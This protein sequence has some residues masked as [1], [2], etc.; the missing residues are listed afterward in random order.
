MS[1]LLPADIIA[2]TTTAS[3]TELREDAGRYS[4]DLEVDAHRLSDEALSDLASAAN[5]AKQP[6]IAR[7]LESIRAA[8]TGA[9]SRPIPNF[10]AFKSVLETFLRRD[11]I[12]GWIYVQH[13]DGKLYPELVVSIEFDAGNR[14]RGKETPSV[15]IHTVFYGHEQ[16]YERED[17]LTPVAS[18][19]TRH[20]FV[21]QDVVNRR[22]ADVLAASGIY[23]ETKALRADHQA[24]MQ[25]YREQLRDSFSSQWRITGRVSYFVEDNYRRR[26][27]SLAGHRAIHDLEAGD[28]GPARAFQESVLF[29][30]AADGNEC[31]R[32]PEHAVIRLFDLATHEHYWVHADNLE[33][34]QYDQSLRD[35]LV[36][37]AAHRDL[38]DVLTTNVGAFTADIIEGKS[39]G[40]VILCKGPPGV[41]K[42]LTAEVYAE[43]TER[44][45]LA[46]HTGT[47]GTDAEAIAQNLQRVFQMTKR[48]GCV[49]LLDEADVFVV[50]RGNDIEQNAIVAEFLR[51]LEYFDGLMFMTTNRPD[52][53]DE[54]IISRCAAII[55]YE[56]PSATD[57]RRVWQVLADQFN[58]SMSASLLE[59]LPATF[60]SIAPRDVKMLLRLAMRVS[61]A[62][63]EPLS[64]DTL[65]RCAMFRAVKIAA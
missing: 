20:R 11:M 2:L 28:F 19:S 65:R 4:S 18:R 62:T 52:D 10:L 63:N 54:A 6:R 45:L 29:D 55:D 9:F 23:K 12:D 21:P 58:A 34:Y 41:G 60:P 46:V 22:I 31:G 32:I 24:A 17:R 7:A 51:S 47:L 37:P 36:L 38:L 26:G 27:A 33:R 43:L 25:R 15:T 13:D 42:T 40:N 3:L 8:R 50:R 59:A 5:A 35:K 64:L 48:W 14:H 53:I 44:P 16:A 1:L 57:I 61:A 49:L 56:I 30:D 39:A